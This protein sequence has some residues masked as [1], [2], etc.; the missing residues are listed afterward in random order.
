MLP[1]IVVDFAQQEAATITQARVVG[2]ELMPGIDHRPRLGLGP[3]FVAAEQ[4]GKHFCLRLAWVQVEQLH[5]C[6]ACHHQPRV[7]DGLWQHRGGEG[8]AE[9]GEAV[10]ESEFIQLFQ[11]AV[12]GR[13]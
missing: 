12:S 13:G 4:F 10:V 3:E 2:A 7:E 8:I 5:G 9:A 1:C 11:G 6:I